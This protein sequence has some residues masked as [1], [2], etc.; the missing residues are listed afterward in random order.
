LSCPNGHAAGSPFAIVV[1]TS[2]ETTMVYAHLMPDVVRDA[3]RV[4]DLAAPPSAPPPPPEIRRP[5]LRS[6]RR[7]RRGGE[8]LATLARRV[9]N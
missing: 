4:L 5:R 7:S 8:G 9:C 6:P 3:V 2:I 1:A